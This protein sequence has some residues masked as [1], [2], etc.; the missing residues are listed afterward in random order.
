MK[1]HERMAV[2]VES[3]YCTVGRGPKHPFLPD[4]S[5][6]PV[7][8]SFLER[9]P[10]LLKD[11]GYVEFLQSYAG[12]SIQRPNDEFLVD[13][14]GFTRASTNMLELPG[15]MIDNH[16]FLMFAGVY[17]TQETKTGHEFIE[18]DFA[19]HAAGDKAD[20][21]YYLTPSLDEYRWGFAR[22]D[23]WLEALVLKQKKLLPS[24]G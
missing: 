16:G 13:I 17:W 7:I 15:D 1:I 18:L 23:H 9:Y 24:E 22:F 4:T 6:L 10:F 2:F 14:Y 5:L 12:A 21:V 11:Q 8:A 3:G 20:G 19:F